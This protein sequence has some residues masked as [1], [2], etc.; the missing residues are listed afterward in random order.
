[1]YMFWTHKEEFKYFLLVGK[2]KKWTKW[3][4]ITYLTM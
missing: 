2:H 4:M 3:T 1:M